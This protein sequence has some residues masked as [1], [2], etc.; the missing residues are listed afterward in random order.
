M[1]LV[2][3]F[4]VSGL[5]HSSFNAAL[6]HLLRL[7]YPDREIVFLAQDSHVE[8]VGPMAPETV[9]TQA[10]LAPP[11]NAGDLVSQFERY[12]GTGPLDIL[13]CGIEKAMLPGL[14]NALKAHPHWSLDIILHDELTEPANWRSRNPFVRRRDAF[15][16]LGRRF[17]DSIRFLVLEPATEPLL[18]QVVRP[19]TRTGVLRHPVP[20]VASPASPR[21][22]SDKPRISF[23]G[24]P[25]T[26]KGYGIFAEAARRASDRFEFAVIGGRTPNYDR[27]DDRLFAVPPAD[28]KL[29][30]EVFDD[31]A[32]RSDLVCL[33]LNPV[34][35]S[36]S[37]SGTMLDCVAMRL[38]LVTTRSAVADDWERRYGRF[39]YIVDAPADIPAF[40]SDLSQDRLRE[41]AATFRQ[42]L[43]KAAA[44]RR[45]EAVAAD[46]SLARD[47]A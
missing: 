43:D 9:R 38:P 24:G 5:S 15:G 10:F 28:G 37:A 34:R 33:P 4:K 42:A 1:I 23:L 16:L 7:R 14:G 25:F 20:D 41:D 8:A 32:A 27:A 6:L 30:R 44:D 40:I 2:T 36:W 17:P 31:L 3:D 18:R 12:G 47:A 26:Y 29:S 39:A 13:L 46:F 35:Y 11:A 45:I 21:P 19:R 22:S